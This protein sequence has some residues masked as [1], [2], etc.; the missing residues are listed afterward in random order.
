MIIS[1]FTY[2]VVLR[3]DTCVLTFNFFPY[4]KETEK[5][6]TKTN[7]VKNSDNKISLGKFY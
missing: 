7:N 5:T 3:I 2:A 4:N 6:A 1:C